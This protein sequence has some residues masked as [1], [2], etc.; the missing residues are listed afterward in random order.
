MKMTFNR[1]QPP[2]GRGISQQ[3]LARSYSDLN[4]PRN[5]SILGGPVTPLFVFT[6]LNLDQ[7]KVAY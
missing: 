7:N 2:M 4:I 1:R 3:P 6:F 5:F